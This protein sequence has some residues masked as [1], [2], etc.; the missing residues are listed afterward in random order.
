VIPS[1]A[2]RPRRALL[3]IALGAL[4]AFGPFTIDSYL[5]SFPQLVERFHATDAAVQATLA[6]TMIGFAVGQLV[7]GP[8]SDRI[9]RRVP[10]VIG[11]ALHVAASLAVAA[12]HD[13]VQFGL[14]RGVQGFAAAAGAVVA[15]AVARD[16]FSGLAMVRALSLVALVSGFAPL[17]APVVGSQL[18]RIGDWRT[19]F[20]FLAVYAGAV[21]LLGRVA[22]PESL[23]AE[24]RLTRRSTSAV[25]RYR[26]LLSDRGFVAL[27]A[28]GGLRFTALFAY[29][30]ASPFLFQRTLGLDAPT[31]GVVFA[32]VTL[33]MMAGV[34]ASSRLARRWPPRAVLSASLVVIAVAGVG[35]LVAQSNWGVVL[36]VV[37][38]AVFMLGCG[39]G[40]P[41]IQT[42]ALLDH[43]A[44]AGTAAALVGASSFGLAGVLAPVLG[45]LTV[46]GLDIS[47]SLGVT[48][49]LC[50]V[51]SAIV[52]VAMVRPSAS[53]VTRHAIE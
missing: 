20:V 43:P 17:V 51:A 49:L 33:G 8:L 36:Y 27:M 22:V 35:L 2:S 18:L 16:V 14:A 10:L 9:G 45:L 46:A 21:L 11:C 12:S 39:L 4:T 1:V 6:G 31:F 34:Q 29:L 52:L 40:L 23:P 37:V 30:Q 19:I 44:E 15:L 24:V 28:L 13:L 38:C 47:R 48:M 26:L 42:L 41:M 32:I 53:L 25:A 5:P 50:V 3:L 7:V